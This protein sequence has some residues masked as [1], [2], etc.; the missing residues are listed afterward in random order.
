MEEIYEA[1]TKE[2]IMPYFE[3][4]LPNFHDQELVVCHNDV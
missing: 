3:K 4:L 2:D 1:Y